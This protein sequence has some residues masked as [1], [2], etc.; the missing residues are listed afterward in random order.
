MILANTRLSLALSHGALDGVT[1]TIAV[2]GPNPEHDL[3]PL[4]ELETQVVSGFAPD[5]EFF[6]SAG[7]SARTD[8][9]GPFGA[10][11]VFLP[12]SKAQGKDMIAKAM[13]ATSGGPVLVD[14]QKTDG[15][16]SILKA[17]R[18]MSGTVQGVVS[19]SHGKIFTLLGGDFS[20]WDAGEAAQN[21][22]G[23]MTSPGVFSADGIDPGSAV[24]TGALPV[25]IKGAVADLGAGW[26]FL[27][28]VILK[29]AKVTECH[30]FEA[31]FQALENARQNIDDDRAQFHWADVLSMPPDQAFDHVVTNP[32][33]HTA[34][35]ANPE[36]G[37]GFIAAAARLLRPKGTLWLVANRHLPYEQSLLATFR[38]V[39]PI[40]TPG[41]FKVFKATGAGSKPQKTVNRRRR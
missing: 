32:P 34:R 39:E 9:Q 14:G 12:R 8:V 37:R 35:A 40:A 16:D 1:G 21:R 26:G 6:Q 36:L 33:F 5:H 3:S 7:F 29:S 15:V 4:A 30:L 28:S 31:D 18:A 25:D 19:K 13:K 17:C 2:I 24:L 10:A 27:S 20:P 38:S 23:F 11:L 22:D 41:A